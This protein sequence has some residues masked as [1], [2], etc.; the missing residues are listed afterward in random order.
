MANQ[1]KKNKHILGKIIAAAVLTCSA[2]A[3]VTSILNNYLY[4]GDENPQTQNNIDV[5]TPEELEYKQDVKKHVMDVFGRNDINSVKVDINKDTN[6]VS[7]YITSS[8]YFVVYK[9][10][11]DVK[12]E[13]LADVS[14]Y[15]Q[16]NEITKR[17]CKD[18]SLIDRGVYVEK[19]LKNLDQVNNSK[20]AEYKNNGYKI[21]IIQSFERITGIL[22]SDNKELC[23]GALLKVSNEAETKFLLVEWTEIISPTESLN[24]YM[25]FEK[26]IESGRYSFKENIEELGEM[27]AKS[28]YT[29]MMGNN[30]VY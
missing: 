10:T 12:V 13:T 2:V 9:F 26:N 8:K 30:Y 28:Y 4:P 1:T 24:R 17:Y 15:L 20:I 3:G 23:C 21:S 22:D 14:Q 16:E 27:F 25:D 5:F 29:E 18:Y 6:Q 7:T 11:P 19:I